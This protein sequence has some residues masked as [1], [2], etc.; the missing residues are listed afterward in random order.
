MMLVNLQSLERCSAVKVPEKKQT[1]TMVYLY[2]KLFQAKTDDSVLLI[3]QQ[4][5]TVGDSDEFPST[6]L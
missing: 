1:C 6:E 4:F 5:P 2:S 3:T